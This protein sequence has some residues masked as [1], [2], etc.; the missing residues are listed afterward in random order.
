MKIVKETEEENMNMSPYDY[1]VKKKVGYF[2]WR[3]L[4]YLAEKHPEAYKRFMQRE[5]C[6]YILSMIQGMGEKGMECRAMVLNRGKSGST[7]FK[8]SESLLAMVYRLMIKDTQDYLL[9]LIH[10]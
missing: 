10:I 6:L 7:H 4:D 9:S 1:V 5:D 8:D 3:Y 2:A